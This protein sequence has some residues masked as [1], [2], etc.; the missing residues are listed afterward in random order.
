M[1]RR[2]VVV[3]GGRHAVLDRR[4][5]SPQAGRREPLTM[6][7]RRRAARHASCKARSGVARVPRS[8]RQE[9]TSMLI[10]MAVLALNG[11]AVPADRSFGSAAEL[12]SWL[13]YYHR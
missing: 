6:A 3:L 11:S 7:S 13:T 2:V 12:Q 4:R 1:A 8:R 5:T 9:T 10:A